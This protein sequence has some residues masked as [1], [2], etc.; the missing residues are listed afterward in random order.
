MKET[1]EK[2]TNCYSVN[3]DEESAQMIEAI[4]RE[5]QRKPRELLRLLLKP[6]IRSE[7]IKLQTQTHQENQQAPTVAQFKL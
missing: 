1:S 5:Q 2:L 3:L 7:W 6:I 4:A